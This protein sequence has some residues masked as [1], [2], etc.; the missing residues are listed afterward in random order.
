MGNEISWAWKT[1]KAVRSQ[2]SAKTDSQPV[3]RDQTNSAYG[4]A[5]KR[6]GTGPRAGKG[7]MQRMHMYEGKVVRISGGSMKQAVAT[8]VVKA[9]LCSCYA[10]KGTLLC[11][12]Q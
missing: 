6:T 5:F 1:K 10:K 11:E 12:I 2:C 9:V 8:K 7:R 3:G 4:A